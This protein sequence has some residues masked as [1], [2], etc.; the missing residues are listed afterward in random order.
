MCLSDNFTLLRSISCS[1]NVCFPALVL[2]EQLALNLSKRQ[3]CRSSAKWHLSSYGSTE[4]FLHSGPL[5][6]ENPW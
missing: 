6:N 2:K 4:K 3:F 5:R 1:I